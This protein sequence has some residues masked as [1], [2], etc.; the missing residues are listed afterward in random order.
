MHQLPAPKQERKWRDWRAVISGK[1]RAGTSPDVP[2]VRVRSRSTVR[3][4]DR[5][6]LGPPFWRR[7]LGGRFEDVHYRPH[8]SS[9][10][11]SRLATFWGRVHL[12]P[13]LVLFLGRSQGHSPNVPV[14]ALIC[15]FHNTWKS[16]RPCVGFIIRLQYTVMH[17]LLHFILYILFI[18]SFL[19]TSLVMYSTILHCPW[20]RPDSHFTV[21]IHSLYNRVWQIN[22]ETWT[23]FPV[24]QMV[25]HGT[26][27]AKI[28]GSILRESKSWKC[29]TATWM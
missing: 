17:I 16:G 1:N 14:S 8:W 29:Q 5:P 15:H 12:R 19:Y 13:H 22:L 2:N 10:W 21:V 28:M 4:C 6:H 23:S 25:E 11:R 26:S 27:N 20:S 24:A 3:C 7:S 9:F 18:H